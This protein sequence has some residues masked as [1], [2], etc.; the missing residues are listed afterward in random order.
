MVLLLLWYPYSSESDFLIFHIMSSLKGKYWLLFFIAKLVVAPPTALQPD[1][2][3]DPACYDT[4][5]EC[6]QVIPL[7]LRVTHLNTL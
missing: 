6:L 3:F 5:R 1:F 4:D 2:V 7:P